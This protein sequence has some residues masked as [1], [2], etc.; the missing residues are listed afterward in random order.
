[1]K[2]VSY[3]SLV[4]NPSPKLKK[5]QP[6]TKH[7]THPSSITGTSPGYPWRDHNP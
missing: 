5:P 7:R 1:V 3:R 2:P 6:P 4:V